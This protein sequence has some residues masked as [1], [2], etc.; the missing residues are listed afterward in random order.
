[1]NVMTENGNKIHAVVDIQD[2]TAKPGNGI[3]IKSTNIDIY[4]EVYMDPVK[5]EVNK[6]GSCTVRF[7]F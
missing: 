6:M 2:H 4:K 5:T 7:C 3:H 1:M